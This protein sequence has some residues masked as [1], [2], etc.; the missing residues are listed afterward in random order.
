VELARRERTVLH[1][2]HA[3]V[4]LASARWPGAQFVETLYFMCE[5]HGPGLAYADCSALSHT[6]SW[7]L[8]PVAP[9]RCCLSIMLARIAHAYHHQGLLPTNEAAKPSATYRFDLIHAATQVW[10]KAKPV[11]RG[12]DVGQMW[13]SA[14]EG[15]K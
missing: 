3:Y 12:A 6:W 15:T 11:V 13:A 5:Y 10:A 9:T 4:L 8:L 7:T 2:S 1:R 14:H